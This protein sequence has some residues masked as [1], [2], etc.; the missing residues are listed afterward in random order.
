VPCSYD[1]SIRSF[2]ILIPYH[3]VDQRALF[4]SATFY[5]A[6]HDVINEDMWVF[7][8]L[9]DVLSVDSTATIDV[10]SLLEV[11]LFN[12]KTCNVQERAFSAVQVYCNSGARFKDAMETQNVAMPRDI[13]R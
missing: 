5:G 11:G 4:P 12:Y 13:V 8:D 3:P 1:G 10:D 2:C 6:S 7:Y 9:S